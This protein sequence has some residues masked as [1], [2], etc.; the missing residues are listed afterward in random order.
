MV[1][2]SSRIGMVETTCEAGTVCSLPVLHVGHATARPSLDRDAG[3]P[4]AHLHCPP[5]GLHL[6]GAGLPHHAGA[7]LGVLEL[8]DEGGDLG[9]AAL[10]QDGVHDRLA[11]VEV[12]HPLGGPVGRHVGDRHPPHLLGVGLEEGAVEAPPEPL[13]QPVLVVRLVLGRADAGPQ[14][15]EAEEEGLPRGRGCAARSAPGAGSR[16]TC[17]CSRSGSCGAAA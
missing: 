12:L 5:G 17:P 1:C 14:V 2:T 15:G 8:L 6:L 9:L 3:Q 13:H 4:R 11:Q 10:G 7:V 16:G